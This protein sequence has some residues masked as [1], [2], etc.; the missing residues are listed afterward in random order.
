MKRDL[1]PTDKKNPT[2]L[3][4]V[5]RQE[6]LEGEVVHTSLVERRRGTGTV[7]E[8]RAK[9][10]KVSGAEYLIDHESL[11]R[12]IKNV[13]QTIGEY[14]QKD[15]AYARYVIPALRKARSD[16]V[17]DLESHFGIHWEIDEGGR[18]RFFA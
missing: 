4:P 18:S 9:Q 5:Q 8:T 16:M 7:I 11:C 1:I 2:G 13:T 10:I 17:S 3:R 6:I 15:N 14:K 12:A